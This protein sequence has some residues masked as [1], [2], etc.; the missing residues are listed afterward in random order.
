M[1]L[2]SVQRDKATLLRVANA[3]SVAEEA[4]EAEPDFLDPEVAFTFSARLERPDL[5]IAKWQMTEGYYLYRDRLDF[6]LNIPNILGQPQL[7]TGKV[8]SD[9]AFGETEVYYHELEV[10]LPLNNTQGLQNILLDAHYQGCADAG[11]CYP[12]I[13]KTALITLPKPEPVVTTPK[14]LPEPND[15]ATIGLSDLL[16]SEKSATSEFLKVDQAFVFSAKIS[17]QAQLILQWQIAEGYYLYRNKFKFSLAEGDRMGEPEWPPSE[18]IQDPA[19]DDTVAVYRQPL[20]EIPIP[21]HPLENLKTIHLTVEYQGC[22]EKGLC[23]PP[24][25]TTVELPVPPM[26]HPDINTRSKIPTSPILS[27]QDRIAQILSKNN[28]FY[29][30]VAFFGFGLLLS[31]TPCVFP[32]IP[33]LS[34]IIVGQGQSVTPYRAFI[35]SLVYILSVS[36]T[37]SIAGVIAGLFG[38]NLQAMFQAPWVI[39]SFVLIFI[40]LSFSMFGFYELQLP[41][42]LQTRL[43]LLSHRQQGGTFIGVAIMG[44]LSA[45]IVGP[46]V[47]APLAGALV[48]IGQTGNALLGGLALFFMSLGMGVPLLLI[49]IS[50]GHWL[51]KAGVW[52]NQIKAVF[53]VLLLAIAIW[54]LERI[55]PASV[56]LLLWAS[57]F[58]ISAV[59]LGALE[60]VPSVSAGLRGAGWRNLLK[61]FSLILLIYGI[62]LLIGAASGKGHLFQPLQLNRENVEMPTILPFKAIKGLEELNRELAAAKTQGKPVILDFYADWCISCKEMEQFTFADA[63]IQKLL[64]QAI[65]LRTDVTPNDQQDKTLYQHFDLFAPPVLLFFSP[66][67]EEQRQYRIVGFISAKEFRQHL[68]GFFAQL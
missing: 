40:A 45:L 66:Q 52:M 6:T 4:E 27:E 15:S 31:L 51:P 65:L 20:L 12:P 57:L 37:Y 25:T 43:T 29:T 44:F 5:L 10:K 22:A 56:T 2:P 13:T 67:G 1:F 8:K 42:S 58:I 53:G 9:P 24:M 48:Y 16:K 39:I 7:P 32:M 63:D 30:L 62:L 18:T 54:M 68:E 50:A 55:I 46:C 3:T 34:S 64:T 61:G 41:S 19:S 17:E 28:L 49:G 14:I 26:V 35:L 36:I 23:Y 60:T 11:L 33:I 59:Y 21:F 38:E 47:A